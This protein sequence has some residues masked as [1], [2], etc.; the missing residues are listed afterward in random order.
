MKDSIGYAV[1]CVLTIVLTFALCWSLA[2]RYRSLR[3]PSRFN[4][5]VCDN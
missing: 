5:N 2:D 1:V 4:E 3:G